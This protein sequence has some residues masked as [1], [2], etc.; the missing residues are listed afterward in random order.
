MLTGHLDFCTFYSIV[1]RQA[2]QRAADL[3]GLRADRNDPGLSRILH[4]L[5]DHG[6]KRVPPC[7]ALRPPDAV[8]LAGRQ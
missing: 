2:G 8:G 4:L 5:C 3:H 1:H 6:R 7:Q